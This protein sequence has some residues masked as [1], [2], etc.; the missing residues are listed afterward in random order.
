MLLRS[1]FSGAALAA[2]FATALAAQ[3]RGFVD[4][5]PV[6]IEHGF[7]DWYEDSN[8]TRLD[9]CLATNGLC[10]VEGASELLVPGAPFPQNF[11]GSFTPVSFY[12]LIET[13]MPTN[14][15]GE[16]RFELALVA[17]F[18]G[19]VVAS[20]NQMVSSAI[21]LRAE[22]L[23]AGETYVATTPVGIFSF[24]AE[25]DDRGIDFE[26][27]SLAAAGN[28]TGVLTDTIG[29]PFFR[30]DSELPIVD[31]LGREYVGDPTIPHTI[32]GSPHGTNF[33]RLEGPGV[34]GPGV[35]MVQTD[36]FNVAGL[37]SEDQPPD[38]LISIAPGLPGAVNTVTV[39]DGLPGGFTV[40]LYS[41]DDDGSLTLPTSTCNGLTIDL[42]NPQILGF[43]IVSAEGI[44]TFDVMVPLSFED[45]KVFMQAIDIASCMKTPVIRERFR[46]GD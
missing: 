39:T 20:G 9:L 19:E 4:L 45:T 2:S 43:D 34:G 16:A 22:G 33:F 8:L 23:V 41:F 5:G 18:A 31:A 10:I 11:G 29:G 46:I 13:S 12:N 30:W 1:L 36:L 37:L 24:V 35:N 25:N 21:S 28:F 40:F 27:G 26:D 7:P 14:G 3:G 38:P 32:T 44:S 15:D 17:G 6:N 42:L